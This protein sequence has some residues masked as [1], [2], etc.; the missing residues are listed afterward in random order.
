MY[1]IGVEDNFINMMEDRRRAK[2][3]KE[4]APVGMIE[5]PM[6]DMRSENA[7]NSFMD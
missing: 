1:E 7:S 4:K 6:S 5:K 3:A 2:L